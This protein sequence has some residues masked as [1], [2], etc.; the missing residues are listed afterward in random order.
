M[1][2][3]KMCRAFI[4]RGVMFNGMR[5]RL[6]IEDQMN[7]QFAAGAG[8][9]VAVYDSISGEYADIPAE[10]VAELTSA[11]ASHIER[12]RLAKRIADSMGESGGM[13]WLI[14]LEAANER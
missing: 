10:S 13:S 5:V 3:T 9:G 8:C 14:A 12:A 2:N 7:I 1:E 11:C 4:E 6:S